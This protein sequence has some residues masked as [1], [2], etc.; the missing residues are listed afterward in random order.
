MSPHITT[1]Q[2]GALSVNGGKLLISRRNREP[3]RKGRTGQ[4]HRLHRLP[5]R[6]RRRKGEQPRRPT[7]IQGKAKRRQIRLASDPSAFAVPLTSGLAPVRVWYALNVH[8]PCRNV[9]TFSV[10]VSRAGLRTLAADFL[11]QS[12]VLC[13]TSAHL[14]AQSVAACAPSQERDSGSRFCSP[15]E[16]G[17]KAPFRG[18]GR[19]LHRSRRVAAVA[20]PTLWCVARTAVTLAGPSPAPGRACS[21]VVTV[22]SLLRWALVP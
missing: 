19:N 7:A 10:R 1:T 12:A 8:P 13:A 5:G 20:W 2:Q 15:V 22:L 3:D 17:N 18:S 6:L 4:V 9:N 21:G 11:A 16:R 14:R